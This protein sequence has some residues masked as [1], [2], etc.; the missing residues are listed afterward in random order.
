LL[1]FKEKKK[2]LGTTQARFLKKK[3]EKI[4]CS[5]PLAHIKKKVLGSGLIKIGTRHKVKQHCRFSAWPSRGGGGTK[6][7]KTKS[8]EEIVPCKSA[9]ARKGNIARP[10]K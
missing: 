1:R 4:P 7:L 6:N 9:A 10:P 5:T 3:K 2:W 8:R